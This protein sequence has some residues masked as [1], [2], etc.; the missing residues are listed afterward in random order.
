MSVTIEN[1]LTLPSLR[2]AR[3]LAG[4]QS[5][6]RIVSSISVLEYA[7]TTQ[8]QDQI[9]ESINFLGGELVITGFCS[10]CNDV[11]AQCAN[12]KKLASAGEVGMILYYVGLILPRV[13]QRLID[14]SN[15][16]GFVLICMPENEPGLRYSEVICE[17]MDAVIRD[18]INSPS[19]SIDLLD[20]VSR[21]PKY[22]RTIDT[23]LRIV[24][25]RL[26]VSVAVLDANSRIL[27][28]LPWPRN[29]FTP[30]DAMVKAAL[31]ANSDTLLT[32]D[33][34]RPMW[35]YREELPSD[36]SGNMTLVIFSEGR[37]IESS[38]WKQTVEGVRLAINLW[39]KEHDR[40]AVLELVRSIIQDEPIK[41][42]RLADIYKIDV[43]ALSDMWILHNQGGGSLSR[44]L[45]GVRELSDQYAHV[46]ICEC[47]EDDILIFPVGPGTL[48]QADIW[49]HALTD[50]CRE[51]QIPAVLTR[52]HGLKQTSDVKKAYLMNQEY[53]SDASIVFPKRR[54]FTLPEIMFVKACKQ[55]TAD[56]E[57]GIAPYMSLLK[58]ISPG[59]DGEDVL[60][61]LA[62][63]L[64]DERSNVT[65][66]AAALFVH[67][68]TIKYRLQKAS[69]TLGF[70]VGDMPNSQ[71]LM[72]AL[73]LRRLLRTSGAAEPR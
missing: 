35:I 58:A 23:T 46:S 72:C 14:L 4:R 30:W 11:D 61:T 51:H 21:L 16:L 54:F 18:Q 64:L 59:R 12:I 20:Q 60:D 40:I 38:L 26:R 42:R 52:C 36:S 57:C 32:N 68:N 17:V 71:E 66:T 70:R 25:D 63:Y 33:D 41:M 44:W 22:Q 53:V 62:A 29:Q 7:D 47:Y 65:E 69:D 45:D 67:K 50:Y 55:T 19:F 27:S 10:V 37:Q 49:A 9:F 3:V 73:G 2:R 1:I 8:T 15:E 5:L 39:G 56:G 28:A 6:D 24:S 31:Y 43:A 13:D 34:I 48:H